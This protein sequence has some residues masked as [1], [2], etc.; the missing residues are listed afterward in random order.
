MY[1][2]TNSLIVNKFILLVLISLLNI[3]YAKEVKICDDK[4]EWAPY[5][6]FERVEGKADKTK[7]TGAVT[8]LLEK[9]FKIVAL[10][11]SVDMIPW[12]RCIALVYKYDKAK[13]YEAFINGAYSTDR[14]LKYHISVPLYKTHQGVFYSTKKYP[15]GL[16][17][18]KQSDIK[19]FKQ[20][21]ILGY[22]LTGYDEIYKLKKGT[23][24][25]QGAKDTYGVLKKI[26]SGHCDIFINSKETVYGGVAIGK[27]IIP[28][29]IK[30]INM[31]DR[32]ATTFH[33]FIARKSPRAHEL[34]S[35]I[36]QAILILQK[37]GVADKIFNKYIPK[38]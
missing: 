35:K 12:A 18:Y 8:E 14:A 17:F 4:G 3:S 20:C 38:D 6:Y 24:I 9:I 15:D 2:K 22:E 5:N 32:K 28:K 34:L 21:A 16:P 10:D 19:N 11:Y 1:K 25:D 33:L 37:N 26:S 27:Y 30:S 36:N 29:D 31:P 13:Q 7:L 23:Q